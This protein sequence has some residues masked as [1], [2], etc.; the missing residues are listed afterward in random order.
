MNQELLRTGLFNISYLLDSPLVRPKILQVSLTNRCNLRCQ[1]CSVDKYRSDSKEEMTCEELT[2]ILQSAHKAFGITHLV[3]TGGEPL[4][5]AEKVKKISEYARSKE[6]SV[7]LTTNGYLLEEHADELV[8]SG[9]T[10][11]HVSLDGLEN[12]HNAIRSNRD[13]FKKAVEGIK[14]L[15]E[16]R[17]NYG[18]SFTVV[19]ATLVLKD[20]IPELLELY[21]F[22]DELGVDVFDLLPYIPDNTDFSVSETTSLWPQDPDL[23]RFLN[24]YQQMV[25]MKT[26]HITLSKYF[27]VSLI[28]S[29][30]RKEMA[31]ADWKCFAGF[32]NFFIT[33]SDPKKSG[34][35]E[36]C[37]FLCKTHIPL[38]DFD[39][40]LERIWYSQEAQEARAAIR[41][42]N[43]YC[44]QRCFSLP[45]LK[46]LIDAKE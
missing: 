3:L 39:Y 18:G 4:L 44:Y 11:F 42:C 12:T 38:R 9:V 6:M 21:S 28:M 23:E 14:K 13:S 8:K 43:A 36:P 41:N 10:H 35:F 31:T 34:R 32:L 33:L 40:D 15:L 5:I 17:K 1:M 19:A 27:D 26:K 16:L 2:K 45:S 25:M 46:K 24:I 20:N 29:Y 7:V 30:Y 22:L 37:L